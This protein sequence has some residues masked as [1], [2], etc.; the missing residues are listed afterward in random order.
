VSPVV[1]YPVVVSLVCTVYFS[2]V[3]RYELKGMGLLPCDDR[4]IC[5]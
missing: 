2:K 3:A 1:V 5:S 4:N